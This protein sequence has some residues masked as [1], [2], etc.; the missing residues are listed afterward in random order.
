MGKIKLG[1]DHSQPNYSN[2]S[3][4]ALLFQAW[5]FRFF[6]VPT[7]HYV[8]PPE[9]AGETIQAAQ[10]SM[11]VTFFH[12]GFHAWAIYTVV[13]LALA[14]FA[15]RHNLPLKIRSALYPIIGQ[16]IYGPIG[17]ADTFATIGTVFGVATTLGFGVTHLRATCLEF[18]RQPVP[19]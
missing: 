15:Y 17:D 18:N 2:A 14:Y 3:W 19:K 13:G 4:F 8:S 16:K 9:G 1:P 5:G 10:Q 7:L 6:G 11:R 12:W